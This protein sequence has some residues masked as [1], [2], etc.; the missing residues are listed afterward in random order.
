MKTTLHS[1]TQRGVIAATLIA[2]A[3]TSARAEVE[4][5]IIKTFSVQPGS[6]LVVQVDRGNI[7]VGTADSSAVEVTVTRKAGGS[8]SKAAQTLKEHVV[9]ITQKD[10][11][12]DVRAEFPGQKSSGWSWGNPNLKVNYHITVPRKFNVDLKTAGGDVKINELTGKADAASSGGNLN[13][14]K[15]AGPLTAR[16]SGGNITL[17]MIQGPVQISTSGGNLHLTDVEG[18]VNARTSGGEIQVEK[19]TGHA[20]V[21]TSGGDIKVSGIKGQI[22]AGTSGGDITAKF[23]ESPT[24]DSSFKTSGGDVTIELGAT[25]AV[26]LDAATSGDKVMSDFPVVSTTDAK[27]KKNK[28]SGKINGG[29]PTLVARTSGGSV[30]IEKK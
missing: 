6:Q 30:R 13:F 20:V 4:D 9:T 12:V 10:N 19:I 2:L 21:K 7:E 25:V 22:E 27:P 23:A 15:I 5:K 26:D 3:A 16:T 24:G 1:I 17:A 28:L 18:D 8:E 14:T 29:G 11:T